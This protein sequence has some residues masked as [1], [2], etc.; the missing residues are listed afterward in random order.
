MNNFTINLTDL[1]RRYGQRE[2]DFPVTED[3]DKRKMLEII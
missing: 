2:S 1:V 3:S